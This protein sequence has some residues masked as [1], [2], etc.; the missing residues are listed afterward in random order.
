MGG[1]IYHTVH[2]NVMVKLCCES[3][4]APVTRQPV[5]VQH[6]MDMDIKE[7]TGPSHE[8]ATW[9]L[10]VGSYTDVQVME[11]SIWQVVSAITNPLDVD[12]PL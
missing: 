3:R 8:E 10:T 1:D 5:K 11:G 2:K 6:V 7:R 9:K 12:L 4:S